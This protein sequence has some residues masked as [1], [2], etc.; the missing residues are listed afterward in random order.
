MMNTTINRNYPYLIGLFITIII[1]TSC[2]GGS[3]GVTVEPTTSN[4]PVA[5]V[6]GTGGVIET[7]DKI[8]IDSVSFSENAEYS[9]PGGS[10]ILK[11]NTVIQENVKLELEASKVL[12]EPGFRVNG[13]LIV[14]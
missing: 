8:E 11:N 10:I 7:G 3:P 6:S 1:S 5:G 14:K 9:K 2:V 12:F 13:Q 4:N